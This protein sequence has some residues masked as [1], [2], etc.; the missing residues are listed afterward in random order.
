MREVLA[1]ESGLAKSR[2]EDET[3]LMW[4]TDDEPHAIEI[5]EMLIAD[6]A[7]PNVRNK[8][9]QTAGD[10]AEIRGLDSVAALLR[11]KELPAS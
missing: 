1:A 3:P 11:S 2:G 4:L 10:L 6:G 7:D 8:Q 5:A 9:G